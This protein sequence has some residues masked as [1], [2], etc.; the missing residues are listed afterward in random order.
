VA[1]LRG[2]SSVEVCV[3]NPGPN[4]VSDCLVVPV[5]EAS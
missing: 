3:L 1:D 2:K 5:Q 4:A